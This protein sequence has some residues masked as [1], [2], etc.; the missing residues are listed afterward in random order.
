MLPRERMSEG[1]RR[2][3][4]AYER[5]PGAPFYRREFSI[6]DEALDLWKGSQGM[7]ADVPLEQLFLWDPPG[8]LNLRQLGWCE[9]AFQPLFEVKI[10]ESRG[11]HELVQ[12]CAGRALLCFTGRR[13]GFMP[14]YV[15]HPVKDM[16]S[17]EENVKWRMDPTSPERYADLDAR[18]AEAV[19]A[20]G[21]GRIITQ[22]VIGAYMYLRS[23]IGPTGLLYAFYDMP[24]VIHDCMRTWLALA[25]AVISRHQESVTIDEIFFGEDICYNHGSLIS[26]DMMGEFLI[27]YYQQLIANLKARQLDPGRHLYVQIDTDGHAVPVIDIYRKGIGMDVMSPFEVASGCDVVEIGRVW[28]GLTLGGG[29][30][31][32]VLAMG[33]REI[34]AMLDRIIPAMRARGGFIPMCDH[35]VPD[36]V[37][38]EDYL[39]YRKR[40]VELGG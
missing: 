30:D 39:H 24:D 27:P 33:K 36:N 29:I 12:D 28:P 17:W 2:L 11:D 38:Y 23:L 5:I 18:M 15:D 8:N 6:W 7:P 22:N 3:R 35:G 1:A 21:E 20:A 9:A 14:E 40:L 31:K 19:R 37:T 16:R 34:D 4:A 26:P 10:L 13:H 25:D 32:R